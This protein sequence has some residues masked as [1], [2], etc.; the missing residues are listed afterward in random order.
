MNV[1]EGPSVS[2]VGFSLWKKEC[3]NGLVSVLLEQKLFGDL[4]K[5]KYVVAFVN[6]SI[7]WLCNMKGVLVYV[8]L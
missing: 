1:Y 6:W 4:L 5:L 8:M 7:R 3:I 2:C